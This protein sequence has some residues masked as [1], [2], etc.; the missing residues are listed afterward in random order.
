MQKKC[1][2]YNHNSKGT[3]VKKNQFMLETFIMASLR[4]KSSR[5]KIRMTHADNFF[6]IFRGTEKNAAYAYVYM[7]SYSSISL[8]SREYFNRL[9]AKFLL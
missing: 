6:C 3:K 4:L 9:R 1:K 5:K 8:L 2:K 7:T